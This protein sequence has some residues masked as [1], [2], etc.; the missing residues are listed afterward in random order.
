MSQLYGNK[1]CLVVPERFG[2]MPKLI[3]KLQR[4]LLVMHQCSM[5]TVSDPDW[6]FG[7]LF[8]VKKFPLGP[9][10]HAE[11]IQLGLFMSC[12]DFLHIGLWGFVGNLE[13]M[14]PPGPPYPRQ[15]SAAWFGLEGAQASA[16]PQKPGMLFNDM[17]PTSRFHHGAFFKQMVNGHTQ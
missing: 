12:Q 11:I 5:A 3:S 16:S 4:D 14:N 6:K 15:K 8:N 2:Q 13:V 1:I 17:I 7:L 10:D 9:V